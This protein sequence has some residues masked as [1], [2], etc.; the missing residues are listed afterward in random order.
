MVANVQ[1]IYLSRYPSV[2]QVSSN[3]QTVSTDSAQAAIDILVSD[4]VLLD[5]VLLSLSIIILL[6]AILTGPGKYATSFKL[7]L[8]RITTR[9]SQNKVFK[10]IADNAVAVVA[11][12][13]H[14]HGTV[15]RFSTNKRTSIPTRIGRYSSVLS[16][17]GCYHSKHLVM[18]TNS[19]RE[20]AGML[21]HCKLI[22]K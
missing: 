21:N 9:N 20:L 12:N 5:R 1:L 15:S 2:A 8:A 22:K 10:G 11:V 7:W 16:A 17:F 3:L 13:G 19:F 18:P 4:L 14:N 6:A